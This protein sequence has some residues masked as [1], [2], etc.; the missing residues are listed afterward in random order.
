MM[1][2]FQESDLHLFEPFVGHR[3]RVRRRLCGL[4]SCETLTALGSVAVLAAIF[5]LLRS[6]TLTD[7]RLFERKLEPLAVGPECGPSW[8]QAEA[9]GCIYDLLMSAWV[10][11]RCHDA[12]LYRQYLAEVNSTFY[13]DR[14]QERLVAW[15][16]VLNGHH[17]ES[18]IW[19]DGGFHHLH[20][21]YIW[22]RQRRAYAHATATR[23]PMVLDSHCRNETHTSHCVWWNGRPRAWEIDSPNVTRVYPPR[24]PIRCLVGP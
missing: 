2:E 19:T 7:G 10:P 9:A 3:E 1:D 21:T 8:T 11:P 5:Y 23:E 12:E 20:C 18:G 4:L 16:N 24:E 6:W 14:Q 15:D 13:L 22:D 17:P